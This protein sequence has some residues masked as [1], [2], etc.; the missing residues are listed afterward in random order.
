MN[1]AGQE[2]LQAERT[3][4]SWTRT[5]FAVLGNGVLLVLKQL[6]HYRGTIPLLPA[7]VAA[8]VASVVYLVGLRRQHL[9]MQRPLPAKIAPR[10]E[11][12]LIGGLV[13]LLMLVIPVWLFSE[14]V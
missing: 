11:V 3:A 6:P 10:R 5:S 12:H 13:L 1:P 14:L 8:V 9:L 4:L 2:G 7:A